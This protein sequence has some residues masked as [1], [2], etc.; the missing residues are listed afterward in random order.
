MQ[1]HHPDAI[2]ESTTAATARARPPKGTKP[3][4]TVVTLQP[5]GSRA[6]PRSRGTIRAAPP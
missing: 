6:L 3:K 5:S 1:W 4:F 2:V